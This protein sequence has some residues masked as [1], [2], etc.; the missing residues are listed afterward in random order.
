MKF[1]DIVAVGQVLEGF[2]RQREYFQ[3]RDVLVLVVTSQTRIAHSLKIQTKQEDDR[4]SI[5]S[6]YFFSGFINKRISLHQ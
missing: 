3:K 4:K 5:A 6:A 1:D 2:G